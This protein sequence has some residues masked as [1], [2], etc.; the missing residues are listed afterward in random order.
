MAIFF[1]TSIVNNKLLYQSPTQQSTDSVI[2]TKLNLYGSFSSNCI[3]LASQTGHTRSHVLSIFLYNCY[4]QQT[5]LWKYLQ[6]TFIQDQMFMFVL[7]TMLVLCY[8]YSYRPT[9]S[10]GGSVW[11]GMPL[12]CYFSFLQDNVLMWRYSCGMTN[13]FFLVIYLLST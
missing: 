11:F 1:S 9:V 7:D 10:S 4:S 2:R 13:L 6:S 8:K 12:C 3:F 5:I